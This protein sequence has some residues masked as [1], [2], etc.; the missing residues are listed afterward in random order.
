MRDTLPVADGSAMIGLPPSERR[1]AHEVHLPADAGILA[2]AHR[3][4]AH[5][6]GQVDLDGAV[7]GGHPLGLR[8]MTAVSLT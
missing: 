2:H 7:D 4:G 1:T 3:V 6:A 5:L 8:R